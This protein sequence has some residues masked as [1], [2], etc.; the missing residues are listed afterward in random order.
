VAGLPEGT[1]AYQKKLGT[2]WRMLAYFRAICNS[3]R[4][5]GTKVMILKLFSPKHLAKILAFFAQTSVTF[6]KN[7]DHNIG[8]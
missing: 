3:I 4:T 7:I 2:F 1:F 8:F 5:S 6:C